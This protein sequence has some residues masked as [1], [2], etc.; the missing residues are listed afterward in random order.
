M[1]VY[2]TM[3]QENPNFDSRIASY[4]MDKT[5][6]FFFDIIFIKMKMESRNIVSMIRKKKKP[7]IDEQKLVGENNHNNTKTCYLNNCTF[8]CFFFFVSWRFL[9]SFF[10][11]LWQLRF[12]FIG[13]G[14]MIWSFV[15]V[16]I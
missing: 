10:I 7:L 8:V 15:L 2:N 11:Y 13:F 4:L 14:T 3:I 9:F 6:F 16:Y 12:K 1:I 5:F